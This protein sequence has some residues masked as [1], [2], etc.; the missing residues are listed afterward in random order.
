MFG[1]VPSEYIDIL[2]KVGNDLKLKLECLNFIKQLTES[3][4]SFQKIQKQGLK[5]LYTFLWN[6]LKETNNKIV[7]VT[8]Q[9]INQILYLLN[10]KFY[11]K[12]SFTLILPHLINKLNEWSQQ[13]IGELLFN[14]NHLIRKEVISIIQRFKKIEGEEEF[15]RTILRM[16]APSVYEFFKYM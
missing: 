6:L 14:N 7:L 1:G 5:G 12:V 4:V 16:V 8:L 15:E 2:N 13:G 3:E 9:I 11:F 10:E